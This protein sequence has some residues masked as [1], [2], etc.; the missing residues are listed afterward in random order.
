MFI[1][2]AIGFTGSIN[3]RFVDVRATSYAEG[4]RRR[5]GPLLAQALEL[6]RVGQAH[7]LALD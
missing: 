5:V 4:K 1:A 2:S 7:L 3:V 6:C